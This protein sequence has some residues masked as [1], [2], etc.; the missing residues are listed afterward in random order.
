MCGSRSTVIARW[1][2]RRQPPAPIAPGSVC[3]W[4]E[5]A[6][7]FANWFTYYRTRLA[8]AIAVTAESL[9]GL[10]RARS[11]DG[12]RLGYGSINYF[13]EWRRSVLDDKRPV[14]GHD[15]DRRAAKHRRAWC[16]VCGRSRK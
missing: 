5:E 16:A 14:A 11:L 3:T 8:S 1:T 12:L 9:S 7:N 2:T 13:P 10:T 6:Q 15:V 4:D